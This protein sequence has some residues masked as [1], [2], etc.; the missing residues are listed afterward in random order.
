MV[1]FS[2]SKEALNSHEPFDE[3]I[4][5][6]LIEYIEHKMSVLTHKGEKIYNAALDEFIENHYSQG[7][8]N[9]LNQKQSYPFYI[10]G[11]DSQ[12]V[13]NFIVEY[14][15]SRI[16]YGT[17]DLHESFDCFGRKGKWLE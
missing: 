14:L 16:V 2:L 4:S 10:I 3:V 15:D 9:F 7:I 12:V 13:F 8:D 5:D 17:L 1:I 6:L 11:S